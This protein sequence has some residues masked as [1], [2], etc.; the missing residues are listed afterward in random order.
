MRSPEVMLRLSHNKVPKA[1]KL[2]TPQGP[3]QQVEQ[4]VYIW[5]PTDRQKQQWE[6]PRLEL[7]VN[8]FP[9]PWFTLVPPGVPPPRPQQVMEHGGKEASHY[10]AQSATT[11]NADANVPGCIVSTHTNSEDIESGQFSNIVRFLPPLTSPARPAT[12]ARPPTIFS[13]ASPT[14]RSVSRHA[15]L[16][17]VDPPFTHPTSL[18]ETPAPTD[19]PTVSPLWPSPKPNT[20]IDS[21]RAG[22]PTLRGTP[23]IAPPARSLPH[24]RPA[25]PASLCRLSG[26]P[27]AID[28]APPLG[29]PSPCPPLDCHGTSKCCSYT[30]Q[31]GVD[32]A[33]YNPCFFPLRPL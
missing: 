5:R 10:T 25:H 21:G 3:V 2:S 22:H 32:E 8:A 23:C 15:P 28:H 12:S 29:H 7:P 17:G 14:P 26:P 13:I 6:P 31:G 20:P 16:D 1:H 30:F 4:P 9:S 18:A 19:P 24:V 27:S 33:M 11:N